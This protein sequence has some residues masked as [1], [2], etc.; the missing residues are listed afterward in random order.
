MQIE[1]VIIFGTSFI[2]SIIS[3]ADLKQA[4]QDKAPPAVGAITGTISTILWFIFSLTW[5]ATA[6]TEMYVAVGYLWMAF[7][8]TFL[9]VTFACVAYI[10][11]SSV[12][13]SHK[14]SG[15]EIR[16]ETE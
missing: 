10:V 16:E 9:L 6:T 7:A 8:F 3:L 14:K 4:I 15:L 13:M 11:K 2:F 12:L 5:T 1:S